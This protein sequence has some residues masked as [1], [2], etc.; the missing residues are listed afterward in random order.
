VFFV[1]GARRGLGPVAGAR[2]DFERAVRWRRDHPNLPR[3]WPAELD[4]F[5]AEAEATLAEP[6]P[7]IPKDLFTPRK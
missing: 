6:E 3:N 7:E 4:E 1:A 5:Q 2:L